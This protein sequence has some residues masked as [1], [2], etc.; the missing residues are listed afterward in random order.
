M[1]GW[2]SRI[3]VMVFLS[4]AV[5][6]SHQVKAVQGVAAK[7]GDLP[8][9]NIQ[10]PVAVSEHPAKPSGVVELCH[11]GGRNYTADYGEFT[12]FAAR[13]VKDILTR[14]GIRVA[15]SADKHLV[16]SIPQAACYTQGFAVYFDVTV[17]VETGS[18]LK[19][20]FIGTERT[21]DIRRR[22]LA[23][24]GATLKAVLEMFKDKEIL[25]YLERNE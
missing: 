13:S 19:K 1:N 6:C 25:Q 3:L 2:I 9:I 4:F 20:Q 24:S 14:K 16:V 18:G 5:A 12:A 8:A 23:V 10:G 15:H 17:A 11:A 21:H 22:H 7:D